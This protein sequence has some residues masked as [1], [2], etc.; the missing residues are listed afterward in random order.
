MSNV[1]TLQTAA[2]LTASQVAGAAS[3]LLPS[4]VVL[5]YAGAAVPAG[6]LLCN[7][8][9][10][11]KTTY[12]ALFDALSYAHGDP[13]GGSFNLPD[14]RGRFIRGAD[15]MGT[16]AGR[17]ADKALRSAAAVGGATG[18]AVGSVQGIATA[19][20]AAATNKSTTGISAASNANVHTHTGSTGTASNT[21]WLLGV[22]GATTNAF[23]WSGHSLARGGTLSGN[24][25]DGSFPGQ[26]HSHSFT[27][28]NNSSGANHSHTMNGDNETR[29][30]NAY[31][32]YIIK[33]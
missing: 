4:G 27:T 32:N 19:V 30:L 28:A 5:P 17:D 14:Y 7:G 3:S 33:V 10:V 9:A 25:G 22:T 20:A 11:S 18:D 12:A 15:T 21:S 31:V 23:G 2:D 16:A 24:N 6:W 13:G 26:D 29:P 1:H 8:A